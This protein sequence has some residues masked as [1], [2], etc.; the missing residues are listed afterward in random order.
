MSKCSF[1]RIHIHA[2]TH[3]YTHIDV[4]YTK[5]K[6]GQLLEMF[7]HHKGFETYKMSLLVRIG[8]NGL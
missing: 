5:K 1:L 3:I 6:K 2:R 4:C 7:T 8:I